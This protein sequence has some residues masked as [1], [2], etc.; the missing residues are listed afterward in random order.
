MAR[1]PNSRK[2]ASLIVLLAIWFLITQCD[3]DWIKHVIGSFL[4][5][6]LTTRSQIK[7]S[8]LTTKA[9]VATEKGKFVYQ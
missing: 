3:V 7:S 8:E 5:P 4:I 9:A 2:V 1:N 6:M